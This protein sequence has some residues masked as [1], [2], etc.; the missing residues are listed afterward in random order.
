MLLDCDSR[1]GSTMCQT[2]TG[3][4]SGSGNKRENKWYDG[5]SIL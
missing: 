2:I 3:P 5:K 4:L 1:A